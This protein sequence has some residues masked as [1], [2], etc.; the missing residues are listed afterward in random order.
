MMKLYLKSVFQNLAVIFGGMSD[1][2]LNIIYVCVKNFGHV[3]TFVTG[4]VVFSEEFFGLLKEFTVNADE[5]D[6]FRL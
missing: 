4:T 3:E 2:P 5:Y 6:D 1:Y